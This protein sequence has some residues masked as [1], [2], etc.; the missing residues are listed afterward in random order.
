M[1]I[2]LS[3]KSEKK[4]II[5]I[6]RYFFDFQDY[7]IGTFKIFR[8]YLHVCINFGAVTPLALLTHSYL[9]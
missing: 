3:V 9:V 8:R 2:S 4:L 1:I 5:K 7:F 6:L